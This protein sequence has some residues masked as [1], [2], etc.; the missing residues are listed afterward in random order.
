MGALALASASRPAPSRVSLD[1]P[2]KYSPIPP[3][4]AHSTS[5]HV[6]AAKESDTAAARATLNRRLTKANTVRARCTWG[7]GRSSR[8]ASLG[9]LGTE[10]IK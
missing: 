10:T 6:S 8:V 3:A 4:S 5:S 9:S 7:S 1:T 2:R